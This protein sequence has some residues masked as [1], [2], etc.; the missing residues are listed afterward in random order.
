MTQEAILAYSA[1]LLAPGGLQARRRA[2]RPARAAAAGLQRVRLQRARARAS[3][4][5]LRGSRME[6]YYPASIPIHGMALNITVLS[7]A[8]TLN[9]GFIGDRDALPHLQRLAVYTG[10]ALA[11]LDAAIKPTPRRRAKARQRA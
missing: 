6:A 5:Y 4:C 9:V 2:G 1:Y 11:A 10:E 8:G 3:R 7:Y